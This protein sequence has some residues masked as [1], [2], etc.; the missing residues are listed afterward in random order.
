MAHVIVVG[1][2]SAGCVVASR[3]SENGPDGLPTHEVTLLESGP[4]HAVGPSARNLASVNWIDALGAADA[5]DGQ[6]I[7]T[8]TAT[9]TP[10]SYRR[11]HGLGGSGTVNA[12]LALPGLPSDY[13]RWRDVYGLDNWGWSD[14]GPWFDKLRDQLVFSEPSEY[15]P[16]DQAL[17]D[18]AVELGL[19]S[20]VDTFTPGDGAGALGRTATPTE[21]RSSRELYLDAARERPNLL[22]R[23]DAPVLKLAVEDGEVV[24]VVL[25]GGETVRGDHVVLCAG[26]IQTPALLIRTGGARPGVGQGLQDHPA[27]SIHLRLKPG[28]AQ[29]SQGPC[30]GAVLRT[31]SRHGNGDVHLLPCFGDLGGEISSDGVVMAALMTVTSFGEVRLNPDNP[32]APPIIC[33]RMLSTD[34]DRRAMRDAVDILRRILKT[35]AF[36]SIVEEV[37]I[38]NA[39]TSVDALRDSATYE[40]WLDANI[41]DYYHAV[42]TARMGTAD[43]PAAV[44][45]QCGRVYGL[46]GVSVID[47]S[48]MPEVPAANTHLPT[49]MIAERLSAA[50]RDDL[51]STALISTANEGNIDATA[52]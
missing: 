22:V 20:G 49:V 32:D 8:R 51:A 10:R 3:L 41:G 11:G 42:G 47:A 13:D 37:L 1:A 40:S 38:D 14:V 29:P 17:S 43:D 24:G 35:S 7:A 21:R 19:P 2:G 31:S 34:R 9:D 46:A 45:D 27:A 39:G 15:T 30:I 48:I 23:T 28:L 44:V 50:L 25:R 18:A 36:D 6:L 4:D 33:E 5:F 16:L 26:T 52:H 12:M